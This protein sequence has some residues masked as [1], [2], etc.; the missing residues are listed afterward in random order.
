[1]HAQPCPTWGTLWTKLNPYFLLH[2]CLSHPAA[3]LSRTEESRTHRDLNFSIVLLLGP[4][5]FSLH[6]FFCA[7]VLCLCSVHV[8]CALVLLHVCSSVLMFCACFYVRM[9]FCACVL[10]CMYLCIFFLRVCSVHVFFCV[11]VFSGSL[12]VLTWPCQAPVIYAL[13]V[14]KVCVAQ[15]WFSWNRI[16][17]T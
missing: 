17:W 14:A 8:F 15:F 3:G 10:L 9:F 6:V 2:L 5:S 16:A 11:C 13:N 1:M 12:Q 4:D 7:H